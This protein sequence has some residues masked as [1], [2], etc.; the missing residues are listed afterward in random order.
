MIEI[1]FALQFE[2][3]RL[4]N[5]LGCTSA[6]GVVQEEDSLII[7][8]HQRAVVVLKYDRYYNNYY[9]Y[10]SFQL[11]MPILS[12]STFYV[13]G[14]FL[15]RTKIVD[16]FHICSVAF[17][18]FIFCRFWNKRCLLKYCYRKWKFLHLLFPATRGLEIKIKW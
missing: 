6:A 4:V 15:K 11:D 5:T 14:N 3:L 2:L 18:N 1:A 7:L 12:I 17:Y 10:Q 9:I 16:P 8:A 13:G